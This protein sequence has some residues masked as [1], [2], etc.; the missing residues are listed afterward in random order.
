MIRAAGLTLAAVLC[1][2]AAA[3]ESR[4]AQYFRLRREAT[5][6][7]QAGDLATAEARL[8][9]ALA[10]VPQSPGVLI[11]LARVEAAAGKPQEAI[12][13]LRDYGNLDL[14]WDV[15]ADP[16]LKGLM[17][18]PETAPLAEGLL[19]NGRLE[20]PVEVV[21]KLP[22]GT[23]I[24]EG[25]VVHSGGFLVSSVTGRGIVRVKGGATTP[26]FQPDEA[27]G[28]LFGMA[29]D[30][31]NLWVAEAAGPGIPGSS[32]PARTA[33]L[34]I[35]LNDGRLLA[36]YPVAEDGGPH[37]LGDVLV[38]DGAVYASD[39]RSGQ[40]W[41]LPKG[42]ATLEE[43]VPK[44][45]LGSPQG[46]AVCAPGVLLVAD[47]TIGLHRLDLVTGA[48]EPVAGHFAS[49]GTDG[50]F[51]IPDFHP[52]RKRSV[53]VL[54]QNGLSP[55]R[56]IYLGLDEDCRQMGFVGFLVN[57]SLMGDLTLGAVDGGGFVFLSRS[58]W[59]AHDGEGRR[60]PD[61]VPVE[62][63]I[64]RHAPKSPFRQR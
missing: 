20:D 50:L 6:A 25:L 56:V 58:G 42:G 51:A 62:T 64:L 34:K 2:A 40:V 55:E 7:A 60:R 3:P 63:L 1:L 32:G 59:S 39:A 30:G 11:R 38:V 31:G 17:N 21:A 46:M 24:N 18:R 47:Y 12:E 15:A 41:R 10:L 23:G 28:G 57:A 37:Q 35:A 49:V 54:V 53:F 29:L 22:A 44:G 27:T 14:S 19:A 52:G 33:L 16:G 26:F 61:A 8:E 5:T 45:Q 36:R 9:A 48:L 4:L 43:V 13:H